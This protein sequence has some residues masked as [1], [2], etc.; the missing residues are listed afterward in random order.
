ML[1][2]YNTLVSDGSVVCNC[3]SRAKLFKYPLIEG[4]GNNIWLVTHFLLMAK[5]IQYV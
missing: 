4:P 1:F 2:T 5:L 3:M